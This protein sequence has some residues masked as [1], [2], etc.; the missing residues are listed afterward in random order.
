MLSSLSSSL[1]TLSSFGFIF[2]LALVSC[3]TDYPGQ[4]PTITPADAPIPVEVVSIN[5]TTEPIPVEAGGTIGA[6][7]E[8]RLA[9]K[10]GGILDGVYAREGQYVRKGATLAS[11]KTTEIDA[12]V[13]KARQARDKMKRDLE[14][15]QKLY[16]DSAATL[17]QVEALTTGLEVAN[18]DLEIATFNQAYAKVSAP[19]SGRIVKKLAEPG[20]LIAPGTPVFLLTGEGQNSYVLRVGIADRDLLAI[21]LGDRAEVRLDA[22]DG[23]V[24]PARVTEIAAAADPRTGTFEI[25]LTLD[26]KGKTLRNGF[27]GRAKIFPSK[28]LPHYRLPL[29]ALVEGN[30]QLVQ[31]FYPD[32]NGKAASK[33][34]RISRLLNDSFV[35]PAGELEGITEVVTAGAAYLTNGAALKK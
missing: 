35:V 17:E 16:A 18:S 22:Y 20:E 2:L 29:D 8:A 28:T 23:Q 12:Q 11:L 21:A 6:K 25:E 30:G 33:E 26:G 27:I 1:K 15:V 7:Q 4:E 34:V 13:M 5:P 24:V 19:V 14:R 31:V 10:I 9:F 32:I 3:K